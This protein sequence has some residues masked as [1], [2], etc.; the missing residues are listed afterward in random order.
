MA[1]DQRVCELPAYRAVLAV[2]VKNFS[3][4]KA[5]DHLQ[6]TRIIPALLER[7]FQRAG[8][9]EVWAERRFPASEG[10]GYVVGF[11]PEVLPILLGPVVDALQEE[12]A[13]HQEL[14]GRAGPRMRL[15][16]AV[17]PVNDTG[18]CGPGDGSGAP[19]VETH[20]LLDCAPVRALLEDSDPNV[21][22]VAVVIS[23]RVYDDVVAG[24]YTAKAESEFIE[25][26]VQVKSYQR[27]GFLHVPR[28][29]GGLLLRGLGEE[30][31]APEPESSTLDGSVNNLISGSIGGQ[32]L[33]SRDIHVGSG[34]FVVGTHRLGR[35]DDGA[36]GSGDED[37]RVEHG[38]G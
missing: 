20:R 4:V 27:T 19:M 33:Q 18:T 23:G 35:N 38:G 16:I 36:G 28:P 9:A 34:T 3:G 10:D 31:E 32:V 30:P 1:G 5:A 25:V 22:F 21:T 6:L 13:F 11:R 12:L 24:G 8:Y 26:P 37:G 17:G 7:A 2:D 15:S 14:S 29:S